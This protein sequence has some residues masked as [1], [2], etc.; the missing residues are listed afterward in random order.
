LPKPRNDPLDEI[1]F[2]LLLGQPDA[3]GRAQ[4]LEVFAQDV[5]IF[6]D[7]DDGAALRGV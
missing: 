6:D 5:V 7:P 2:E 3:R 1:E 4:A